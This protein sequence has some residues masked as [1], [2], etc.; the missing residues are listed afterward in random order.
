MQEQQLSRTFVVTGAT[1]GIGL[2]LVEQL[3]ERGANVIG[4][5]RSPDRCS[6]QLERLR[7]A[8][9]PEAGLLEAGPQARLAYVVADLAIQEQVRD[10]ARTIEEVLRDW[11]V[12]ALDG[13]V[14]NAG[15]FTFWQTLTP[16]GFETQWA[17]NHLAPFLLTHELLPLLLRAAD[18]RVITVSSASHYHT[19]LNWKDIQLLARYNPLRAYKQ[20][21]LANVLFSAELARRLG[22]ASTVRAVAADPGLVDTGIGEKANSRI[23]RW[24]W[25]LRRRRGMR[26]EQSAAGIASLL[27][28]PAL[29]D[30]PGIYWKHGKPKPPDAYALDEHHG[31]RLWEISARMTGTGE[32]WAQR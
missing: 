27:Y 10:A 13:L 26:P 14:N 15:T 12:E 8:Y 16:E 6:T 2:A 3:L 21:K 7:D 30:S 31:W 5:G 24:I 20:T 25:A 9:L 29:R 32:G 4:V 23:A 11:H 18:A 17:V 19:Q 28:D 1:S 22:D